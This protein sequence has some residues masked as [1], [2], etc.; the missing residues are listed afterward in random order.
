MIL[1]TCHPNRFIKSKGLC[2]SCYEKQLKQKNPEYHARQLSKT[3][4]WKLLNP[5]KDLANRK[6]RDIK[7]KL[8]PLFKQKSRDRM[9]CKT[10]G[11]SQEIYNE[12]LTLQ[13]FGCALCFRKAGKIPLH[14]DHNHQTGVVRGLLCHQCNWYLGVVEHD[15]SILERIN[16]YLTKEK[17]EYAPVY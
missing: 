12:I 13:N 8:D 11:I 14:V 5:E 17:Q 15:P 10:Y 6:R 1:A 3:T 16:V 2:G 4:Q 9:L 7:R